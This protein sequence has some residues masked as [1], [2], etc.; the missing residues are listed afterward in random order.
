MTERNNALNYFNSLMFSQAK[1]SE[2]DSPVT[3]IGKIISWSGQKRLD[4]IAGFLGFMWSS[5]VQ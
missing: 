2:I 4:V 3:I 1:L 5:I